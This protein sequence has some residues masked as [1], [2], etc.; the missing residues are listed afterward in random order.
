[1]VF[2]NGTINEESDRVLVAQLM[3]LELEAP[4]EPITMYITS[5]G[6]L[7]YSGL[8]IYDTMQVSGNKMGR[9]RDVDIAGST[10]AVNVRTVIYLLS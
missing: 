9:T 10:R 7:V 8:A 2:L 3:Y 5:G 1:M 4:G 6:G